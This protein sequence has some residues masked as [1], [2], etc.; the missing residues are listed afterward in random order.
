[1]WASENGHLEAVRELFERGANVNA[2]K[3]TNGHTVLMS[4]SQNGHLEVVRELC[5]R[6]ANVNAARTT[7]GHTVLMWASQKGHLAVAQCLLDH[8]ASKSATNLSGYIAHDYASGES[9][10]VLRDLLRV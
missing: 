4:A 8:G 6:N 9:I 2:A 5:D 1:M 3:T 7:D 10:T